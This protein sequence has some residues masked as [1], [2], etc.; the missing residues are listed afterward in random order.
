MS[1]LHNVK[2]FLAK[3]ANLA[4]YCNGDIAPDKFATVYPWSNMGKDVDNIDNAQCEL[5]LYN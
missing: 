4:R 5:K 3:Y 2:C 1:Q